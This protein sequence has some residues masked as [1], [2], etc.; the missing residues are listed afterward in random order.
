MLKKTNKILLLLTLM[1]GCSGVYAQ[2]F[3]HITG[4]VSGLGNGKVHLSYEM[5]DVVYKDSVQGKAG[6][7]E[8]KMPL[9]ETAICTLS[10]SV[11]Q[12]IK[13]VILEKKP[14]S[15]SGDINKFYDLNIFGASEND[16]FNQYK[17]SLSA[18][19]FKRPEKTGN[20]DED[21]AELKKYAAKYQLVKDTVL[22]HFI[23]A[24]PERVS[25]AIAI[26][27]MYVTYPNRTKAA[28]AYQK[29]A[30]KTQQGFYG[31]KIKEFMDAVEITSVGKMAPEFALKS[32]EG[33][34][35]S[36]SDFKG[37]YVLIDFWASWCG[38]CRL[39]NPNLV[40]AFEKF[41]PHGFTIVGLSMDSS[42]E[43]WL[44]AVKTDN[45]SWIQLNDPKSTSG[46][47]AGIYG[48]KS[49]PA[50][51]LLNP[52]GKIIARNL[53]GEALEKKLSSIFKL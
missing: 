50:N 21:V 25:A 43:S 32:N 14:V 39:E 35:F 11:N 9:K 1:L 47:T 22:N 7:F 4:N 52:A 8:I 12:Q 15:V 30:D 26:L 16:I 24:H 45:L 3:A 38:P 34:L 37:K 28:A 33:K 27:D 5:D 6:V 18:A 36:I 2:E 48:V 53:R 41:G 51:F 23:A 19:A 49:L 13:I 31:R 40:K 29:L 46:K 44:T 17:N 42:K 20:H 10:T